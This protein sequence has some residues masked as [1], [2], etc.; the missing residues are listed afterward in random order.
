MRKKFNYLGLLS[1]LSLVSLLGRITENTGLY[2]FLG[3]IY[4]IR[5]FWIIPDEFF[6]QNVQKSATFAFMAE[7]IAF[8]PF[9]FICAYIYDGSKAVATAFALCFAVVIIAFT[10]S[11]AVHEWR[12]QRGALND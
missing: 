3:F 6:R 8:V 4:F 7:M 5:Y 9:M 1:L 11:L 2:G 12:E 10:L